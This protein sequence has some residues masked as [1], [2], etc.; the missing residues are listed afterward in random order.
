MPLG[1]KSLFGGFIE[2]PDKK[3]IAAAHV[4]QTAGLALETELFQART[5]K[6]SSRVPSRQV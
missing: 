4:Q 2:K 3:R 5:S 1:N 6:N